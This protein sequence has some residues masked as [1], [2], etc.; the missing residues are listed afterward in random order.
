MPLN[1]SLDAY[2]GGSEYDIYEDGYTTDFDG[3]TPP[4]P[5][6]LPPPKKNKQK[7]AYTTFVGEKCNYL[8]SKNLQHSREGWD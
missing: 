5:P 8:R 6:S 7:T 3:I 1:R 4:P 2:D